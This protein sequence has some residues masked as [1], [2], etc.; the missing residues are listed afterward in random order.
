MNTKS[1]NPL[2]QWL[3]EELSQ[4]QDHIPLCYFKLS[5]ADSSANA[6]STESCDFYNEQ[7]YYCVPLYK[8]ISQYSSII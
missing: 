3:L 6:P 4:Q 1:E 5:V 2:Q 7:H 8:P